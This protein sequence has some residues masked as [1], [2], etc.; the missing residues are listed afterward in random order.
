MA[1][2]KKKA[3][4]KKKVTVKKKAIKKTEKD[5]IEIDSKTSVQYVPHDGRRIVNVPPPPKKEKDGKIIS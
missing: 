3:V 1:K 5:H 2:A 4:S